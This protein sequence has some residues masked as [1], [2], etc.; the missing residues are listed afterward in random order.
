MKKVATMQ[1][2]Y[3][4]NQPEVK[5]RRKVQVSQTDHDAA[6]DLIYGRSDT[7][8]TITDHATGE[9]LIVKRISCGLECK[10]ALGIV[11]QG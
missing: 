8:V 3:L 1:T 7:R 10:C 11:A 6:M 5:D 2:L 9:K 4:G